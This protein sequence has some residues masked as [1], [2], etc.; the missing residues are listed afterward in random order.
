MTATPTEPTA[1]PSQAADPGPTTA[2]SPAVL[3]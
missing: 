1:P 2:T 3:P